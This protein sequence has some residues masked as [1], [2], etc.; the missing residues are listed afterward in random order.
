[1]PSGIFFP[2]ANALLRDN[3]QSGNETIQFSLS[4]QSSYILSNRLK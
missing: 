2:S 1:M 3:N 4:L